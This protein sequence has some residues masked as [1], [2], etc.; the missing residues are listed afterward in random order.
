MQHN[1]I[2]ITQILIESAALVSTVQLV[3]T[4]LVIVDIFHAYNLYAT[5]GR[6]FY[7]ILQYLT[8]LQGPVTVR[9]R[10]FIKIDYLN[11]FDRGW[12]QP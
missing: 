10:S 9:I 7:Q 11:I 3:I 4:V 1:Y 5:S 6:V 12:R 2:K 8:F